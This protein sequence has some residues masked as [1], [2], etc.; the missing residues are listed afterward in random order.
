MLPHPPLPMEW[1][2]TRS[3]AASPHRGTGTLHVSRDFLLF[4]VLA[5]A[6]LSFVSIP[7]FGHLSDR[8]GRKKMYMLG[9]A[10]CGIF[11]F[12]YF[13]LLGTGSLALIFIA[14]VAARSFR[15]T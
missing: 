8:I 12:V 2:R 4:A 13:G 10:A 9:A 11:G 5:A 6:I 3:R 14:I 15:T 7:L 1:A